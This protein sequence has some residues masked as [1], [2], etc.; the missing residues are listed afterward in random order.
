MT[1]RGR[2]MRREERRE[3]KEKREGRWMNVNVLPSL[4]ACFI[5]G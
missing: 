4:E 3:K 5:Y 2:R 1:L